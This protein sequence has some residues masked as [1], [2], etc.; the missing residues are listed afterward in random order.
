[1][2][3]S[4]QSVASLMLSYGLLLVAN[5]MFGTLLGLRSKLEGFSTET[6]GF[7]MAGYFV[8][9]LL[10]AIYAVR[11]VRAVGHIRAFAAFASIMSVAVLSHLLRVDP[12]TWFFLRLIAGFCMAGMV[13]V[14]ESWL[15][16]RATNTTRGQIFSLYMMV[17]YLGSGIGQ[18]TLTFG[19]PAEFELFVIASIIFSVALVPVLMTRASAPKPVAPQRMSFRDLFAIS[20]LGVVATVC[21]GMANSS[22]NSLAPVFARDIG[23]SVAQISTFMAITLVGGMVLQYPVGR[24]S[25][26][27]DRRSILLITAAAS[28][29]ACLGIVAASSMPIIWLFAAG[30]VYGSFCYTI[31]PLAA[32]QINDLADPER[33]V[34]VSAGILVAY[35]AGAIMGPVVAGQ[36]MGN[37]G[38]PALFLMTAAITGFLALFTAWRMIR[39]NRGSKAKT[40][41]LP[42]GTLGLSGKQFYASTLGSILKSRRASDQAQIIDPPSDHE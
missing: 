22:L 8:G 40:T 28:S 20:P 23:L 26:R 5:A 31:Y 2:W 14:V 42:L 37:F 25:D 29:L 18:F 32:A 21:A 17:N 33:L 11:A 4:L 35:G 36:L 34:Q 1:M 7:V 38:A 19:D 27:L 16:E 24:L 10:G 41:Y 39:R 3:S 15:N 9:M 6:V 13:M 12:V 30:A